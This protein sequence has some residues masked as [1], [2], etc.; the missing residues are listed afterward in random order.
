MRGYDAHTYGER[1]AEVYDKLYGT[2]FDVE[3]TVQVLAHLA[4]GEPALELAIGTGRI[5][6]PLTEAGI[7]VAGIDISEAMV[8]KLRSK[9]GGEDIPVVIGDFADVDVDG[10]FGLVY[11]VFNTLFGLTTQK[12][13]VRCF[14]NVAKRLTDGGVFLVEAFVPDVTR[15]DGHQRVGVE[16]VSVDEVHLE[17][18]RHDP[19]RQTIDTHHVVLPNG[20]PIEL[21]PVS[22]RYAYP[23]ELDLMARLA[24]LRLRDRWGGWHR[25]AFTSD[26]RFHVSVYERA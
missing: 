14:A 7:Q 19:V 12:D 17:A 13:Q 4:G 15:F 21:Y 1:I 23:S 3:A 6:L 2:L 24:R 8:A 18:S 11:I 5:A 20:G 10:A 26:S 22:I 16:E 9:P 25:E